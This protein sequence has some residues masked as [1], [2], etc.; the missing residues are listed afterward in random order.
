MNEWTEHK[1][2]SFISLHVGE[3]MFKWF[4]ENVNCFVRC[5]NWLMGNVN[6]SVPVYSEFL[7]SNWIEIWWKN[8]V[9]IILIVSVCVHFVVRGIGVN[10]TSAFQNGI[11]AFSAALIGMMNDTEFSFSKNASENEGALTSTFWVDCYTYA[12][13]NRQHIRRW[14]IFCF[15]DVWNSNSIC[16]IAINV[17]AECVVARI[18]ECM[19][20]IW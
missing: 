14:L 19:R 6:D 20:I 13:L 17:W 1:F 9:I 3:L 12:D 5:Q 4:P 8:A 11:P 2:S 15:I 16:A 10:E 18:S 7:N